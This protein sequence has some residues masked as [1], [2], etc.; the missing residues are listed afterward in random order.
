M[1]RRREPADRGLANASYAWGAPTYS[2]QPVTIADQATARSPSPTPSSTLRDF[3]VSKVDLRSG[4]LHRGY[5]SGV[6]CRY[7]CTL[8]DG[9]TTTGTL[10][11][12]VRASGLAGD[13]DPGRI[14]LHV[15]R[16]AHDAAGDFIDPSYVWTGS[17]VTPST[18]PSVTGRRPL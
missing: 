4:R 12:T 7:S 16:D 18:S 10:D 1:H 8:T 17:T 6:P 14:G 13:A 11:V 3:S 15:H 9:P 5:G 2:T